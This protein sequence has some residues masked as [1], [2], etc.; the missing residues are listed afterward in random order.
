MPPFLSSKPRRS[1]CCSHGCVAM[2]GSNLGCPT[3]AV[4]KKW[5]N[6]WS[7]SENPSA[8]PLFHLFLYSEL[9]SVG[10]KPSSKKHPDEDFSHQK[11]HH[12]RL[13]KAFFITPLRYADALRGWTRKKLC[14][15]LLHMSNCSYCFRFRNCAMRQTLVHAVSPHAPLLDTRPERVGPQINEKRKKMK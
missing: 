11:M 8:E 15:V 2:H 5:K 4:D 14:I 3:I 1:R 12:N 10:P 7:P 6:R 9:S 13:F